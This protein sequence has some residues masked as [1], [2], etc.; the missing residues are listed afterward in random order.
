[1]TK[2]YT[3]TNKEAYAIGLVT[4]KPT[5]IFDCILRLKLQLQDYFCIFKTFL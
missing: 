2:N 5:I 1:M 4:G 3:E